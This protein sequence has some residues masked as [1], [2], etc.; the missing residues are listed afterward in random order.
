V[1]FLARTVDFKARPRE[2]YVSP[3]RF[4]QVFQ[5]PWNRSQRQPQSEWKVHNLLRL[6]RRTNLELIPNQKIAQSWR[7]T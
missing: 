6:H 7:A 4:T 1:R 5:V 3:Y 2:I